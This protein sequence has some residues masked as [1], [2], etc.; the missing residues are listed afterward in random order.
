V[1][2]DELLDAALETIAELVDRHRRAE[3]RQA[4]RERR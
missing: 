3:R 2:T 1:S 4:R